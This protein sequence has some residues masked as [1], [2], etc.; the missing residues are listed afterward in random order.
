[1]GAQS[2][3]LCPSISH[4]GVL[5]SHPQVG[6]VFEVPGGALVAGVL[7]TLRQVNVLQDQVG[8]VQV[9][10]IDVG[11]IGCPGHSCVPVH[12]ATLHGHICTYSLILDV[13]V[14]EE[15]EEKTR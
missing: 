14:C 7:A 4:A 11:A 2:T 15:E 12:G 10:L 8:P 5:T 6:L 13:A 3:A 9:G 1:M